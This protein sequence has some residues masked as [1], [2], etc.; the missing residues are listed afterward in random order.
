MNRKRNELSRKRNELIGLSLAVFGIAAINGG[1]GAGLT[2]NRHGLDV[3]LAGA[4]ITV[5]SSVPFSIAKKQEK[6][7]LQARIRGMRL[8]RGML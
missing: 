2:G 1:I 6:R 4:I 3:A 7:E 5:A 8:D